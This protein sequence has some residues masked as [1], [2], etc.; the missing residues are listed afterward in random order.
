[1][2]FYK[3]LIVLFIILFLWSCGE[4][5]GGLFSSVP[6]DSVEDNRARIFLHN[7]TGISDF[8]SQS[9]IV[10]NYLDD[11]VNPF[12]LDES[13]YELTVSVVNFDPAISIASIEISY[14]TLLFTANSYSTGMAGEPAFV[15][16]TDN[17]CSFVFNSGLGGTDGDIIKIN[18]NKISNTIEWA[19][20]R[21]SGVN[22]YIDDN[23]AYI[24]ASCSDAQYTSPQAC[25]ESAGAT[26]WQIHWDEYTLNQVCYID[27]GLINQYILSESLPLYEPSGEFYWFPSLCDIGP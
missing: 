9:D 27:E 4:E 21:V 22:N 12:D 17:K 13:N 7:G 5:G 8:P 16:F 11:I 18:F 19:S 15:S 3:H 6:D 2:K 24:Y 20:F 25:I 23:G 1:M 10:N 26:A 14:D